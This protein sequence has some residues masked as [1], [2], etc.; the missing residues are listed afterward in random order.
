M[1][2]SSW[3]VVRYLPNSGAVPDEDIAAFDGWYADESEAASIYTEWCREYPTFV[4]SLIQQR[5]VRWV[6]RTAPHL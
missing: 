6:K 1:N 4:V 3:G 2:Q 5:N